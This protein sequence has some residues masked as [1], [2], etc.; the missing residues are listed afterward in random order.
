MAKISDRADNDVP[1]AAA[2]SPVRYM[3]DVER[4][5]ADE[6]EVNEELAETFRTII[7][8]THKDLA[9]GF[10][11][12]HAKSH[13]LLKAEFRVLDGLPADYA[14]GLF[15]RPGTY[16]AL[17]R[18]STGA[19]DVLPDSVS[20]L[21]G[22]GVKII[23]VEGDRLEGSEGA[24]TQDFLMANGKAFPAP[25]PKKFLGNLKLLAKTTD[26]AEGSK[27]SLSALLRGT[28]AVIEVFGGESAKI[29][30]MG[31]HPVTHPLGETFF[32]Q[33]AFRYGD[34]IGKFSVAPV[35]PHLVALKD[36]TID[37]AGRDNALR[38]EID[39]VIAARGGEWELRVQLCTDL[40]AMPVEDATVVWDEAESPFRPIGR[41]LVEPQ[42]GWND[43]KAKRIYDGLAFSPWHGLAAHQPLGAINRAR[44]SA[45][46]M[47]AEFRAAFNRCPIHE[48]SGTV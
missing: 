25:G 14:Q 48:P 18:L 42:S 34:H 44:R 2:G 8:T 23:G 36:Q 31:G 27:K 38:E 9:H 17:V 35:S 16:D 6:A 3:P 15:A 45:Y 46:P 32:S 22:I 11:G 47:S 4:I 1:L 10:R 7:E 40:E 21:R 20:L 26:K 37:L 12:V 29:K 24:T 41:I 28:E 39:A 33:T 19:G 30:Q 43:D 5:D 13:A